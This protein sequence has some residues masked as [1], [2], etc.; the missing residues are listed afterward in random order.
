MSV[1]ACYVR[2]GE[3]ATVSASQVAA[4]AHGARSQ[5]TVKQLDSLEFCCS[6]N[7]CISCFPQQMTANG[8]RTR[9]YIM[10]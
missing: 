4:C 7:V 5:A 6:G 1:F 9:K 10:G 8:L 2:A 3:W